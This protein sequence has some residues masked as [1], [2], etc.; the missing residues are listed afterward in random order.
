MRLTQFLAAALAAAAA[1]PARAGVI[2]G[3]DPGN[4][5]SHLTYDRFLA[6]F[7]PAGPG[8]A[9]VPN[10]SP[11][12][13]GSGLDLTG[14]GWRAESPAFAVTL[15]SP[16]HFV[17]AA[18]SGVGGEV[19]FAD[20]AGVVRSYAV[21]G[22]T[23]L[24]TTFRDPVT[25]AP[26]TLA[27]DLLVGTL[28]TPVA[29]SD[30]VAPL[31]VAGVSADGVLG[32]QLLVYGQNPA[33][34]PSPHLGTNAADAVTLASFDG[35]ASEGTAVVAYGWTPGVAGEIYLVGGDSGGPAFLRVGDRL[36]L[37]GVHYG[38]SNPTTSPNPGDVSAS[39]FVPFY[40]D[41]LRAALARDGF[42]LGVL[43]VSA[44]APVPAPGTL[45]VGL[46][47]AAALGAVGL[48]RRRA[49]G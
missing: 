33:Y 35:F 30:G 34:G 40:T 49:G 32:R 4:P 16:R 22:A 31:P 24:T 3:F 47:M 28:A 11:L 29:A 20:A 42:E 48:R 41:Q 5:A 13:V 26:R 18:H 23:R 19:R 45:A 12:F 43:P 46:A 25:G 8:S 6:G 44:A 9:V 39:T 2:S 38:V 1:T 10:A 37:V 27:S 36:A 17:T 15:I 21:A 14:V 7:P